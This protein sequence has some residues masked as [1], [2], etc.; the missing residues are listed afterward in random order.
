[1]AACLGL[2]KCTGQN[3]GGH[4]RAHF[5]FISRKGEEGRP[6]PKDIGG[7][8]MCVAFRGVKKEIADASARDVG[9]LRGNISEDDPR[10]CGLACPIK[11]SFLEILFSKVGEPKQPENCMGDTSQDAK[12]G[13][14]SG[15]L[16]LL[17]K[18]KTNLSQM[19]RW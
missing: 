7:G 3:A 6:A 11:S 18:K 13:T 16:N 4:A 15:W 17:F 10:S 19:C 8:S 1:M 14:E 2:W 5:V 9:M 12:P